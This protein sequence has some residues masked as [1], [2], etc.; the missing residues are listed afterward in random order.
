MGGGKRG[1]VFAA[2]LA[3]ADFFVRVDAVEEQLPVAL[4][5]FSN[6]DHLDNIG[7]ETDDR[8]IGGPR[9]GRRAG[10]GAEGA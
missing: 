9:A 7:T 6:P 1:V 2:A 3:I 8:A 4:D 10:R 5:H